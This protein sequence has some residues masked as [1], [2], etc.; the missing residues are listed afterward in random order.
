[1]GVRAKSVIGFSF[2][3]NF[4]RNQPTDSGTG[5]PVKAR[6][7]SGKK[8]GDSGP[9]P[10]PKRLKKKKEGF[11]SEKEPANSEYQLERRC[12]GM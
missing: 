8:T 4:S 7:L 3:V 1:M 10:E 9:E 6:S 2:R 12:K 11:G 5:Q